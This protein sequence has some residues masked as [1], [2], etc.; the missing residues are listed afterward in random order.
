MLPVLIAVVGLALLGGLV[1]LSAAIRR[2]FGRLRADSD[3]TSRQL[4][5]AEVIIRTGG[6]FV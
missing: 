4:S 3:S 5:E 6:P 2:R 1:V